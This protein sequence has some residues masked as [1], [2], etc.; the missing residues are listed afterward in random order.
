MGVIEMLYP[1]IT[2]LLPMKDV[3]ERV[4]N[5]NLREFAGEPLFYHILRTLKD[6]SFINSII[7]NTDS[8][9]IKDLACSFPLVTFHDRPAELCGCHVPMNAIIDYDVTHAEG[10]FFLQTHSTNPL[11]SAATITQAIETFFNNLSRYDSLFS[12]TK[13]QQRLYDKDFRP[14]NHNPLLL[15][16]TQDLDPVFEENSCIYLFS[17]SSFLENRK[18]RIGGNPFAFVMSQQESYDID[19]EDDFQIAE[20]IFIANMKKD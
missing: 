3:S 15:Q 14:I 5:K 6:V 1:K 7:I 16:N 17:R 19:T 4:P 18:S 20:K 9:R 10:N 13:K 2:A 11:L 8:H 12:V